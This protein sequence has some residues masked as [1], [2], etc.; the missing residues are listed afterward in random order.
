LEVFKIERKIG[1]QRIFQ[2]E[3]NVEA[4]IQQRNS[5]KH[6]VSN[7]YQSVLQF[8]AVY[9]VDLGVKNN[10]KKGLC[11]IIIFDPAF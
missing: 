3:R 11:Q 2:Q 10:Y 4:E 6:P 9:T 7:Q 5:E 8:H 1:C